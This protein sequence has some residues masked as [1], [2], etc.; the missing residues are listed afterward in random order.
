MVLEY[1]SHKPFPQ[2]NGFGV[3]LTETISTTKCF[4]IILYKTYYNKDI[5]VCFRW[6][7]WWDWRFRWLWE[8]VFSLVHFVLFCLVLR[9]VSFGGVGNNYVGLLVNGLNLCRVHKDSLCMI[10][11]SK[12]SGCVLANPY[13]KYT[14][15]SPYY[16]KKLT[17]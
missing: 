3:Q 14:S 7:W 16:K 11:A 15:S 5:S 2:Q 12:T 6:C 13:I 1:N 9:L 10:T 8:F 4:G 17:F